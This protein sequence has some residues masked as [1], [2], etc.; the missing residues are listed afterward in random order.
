MRLSDINKRPDHGRNRGKSWAYAG[1]LYNLD[2]EK[3]CF[4][5]KYRLAMLYSEDITPDKLSPTVVGGI[6]ISLLVLCRLRLR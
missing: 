2:S 4:R 5:D 6:N 3:D 1:S